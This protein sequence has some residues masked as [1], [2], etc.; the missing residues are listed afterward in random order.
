[1]VL[2]GAQLEAVGAVEPVVARI[3]DGARSPFRALF[4]LLNGAG[5]EISAAHTCVE[6]DVDPRRREVRARGTKAHTRARVVR[7][8]E[9]AW[10]YVEH[11]ANVVLPRAQE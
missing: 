4:A 7:V 3:V 11:V 1:M 2:A 6:S 8:A 10:P 5:V 9:W